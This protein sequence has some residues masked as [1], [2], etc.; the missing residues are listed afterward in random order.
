MRNDDN[1]KAFQMH[2][3]KYLCYQLSQQMFINKVLFGLTAMLEAFLF[4]FG[5]NH[6]KNSADASD[7]IAMLII[8]IIFA[9]PFIMSYLT[10]SLTRLELSNC[11]RYADEIDEEESNEIEELI[12]KAKD[13]KV[14]ELAVLVI[15]FV[16]YT[17]SVF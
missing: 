14:G 16:F 2:N 10:M 12:T 9:L 4:L 11:Y 8:Y 3:M 15:A 13:V 6:Y 5:W 17:M 1:K 7:I